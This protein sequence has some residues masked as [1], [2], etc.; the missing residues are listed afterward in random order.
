MARFQHIGG[1]YV[2]LDSILILWG[3][4]K[5]IWHQQA[6]GQV[7]VGESLKSVPG[8]KRMVLESARFESVSGVGG[9]LPL[10]PRL[11]PGV[12]IVIAGENLFINSVEIIGEKMRLNWLVNPWEKH[13]RAIQ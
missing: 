1:G 6:D 3:V 10:V 8:Q 12:Q 5:G 4:E 11:R 9:T 7:F 13:L 2:A